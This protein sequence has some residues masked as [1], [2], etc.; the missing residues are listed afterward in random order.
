MT[1]I[2]MLLG[3]FAEELVETAQRAIKAQRFTVNEVEPGQPHGNVY[4][5]VEE[6]EEAVEVLRMLKEAVIASGQTW[7][8]PG[9]FELADIGMEKRERVE[10]FLEKSRQLGAL[11]E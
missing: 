3:Q 10:K 11:K 8:A 4:R 6:F 9:V 7:D 1:K 2:E 5:M